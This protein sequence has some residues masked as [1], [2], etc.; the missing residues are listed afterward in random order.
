[1]I[2]IKDVDAFKKENP[3]KYKVGDVVVHWLVY[4]AES[5]IY[6]YPGGELYGNPIGDLYNR[7]FIVNLNLGETREVREEFLDDLTNAIDK[8]T[9]NE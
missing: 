8:M 4:K 9:I 7:Y 3:L 6:H 2:T 5:Y 1:M